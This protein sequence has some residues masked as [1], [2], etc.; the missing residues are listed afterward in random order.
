V[1]SVQIK[2]RL[3]RAKRLEGSALFGAGTPV[4]PWLGKGNGAGQGQR[5]LAGLRPKAACRGRLRLPYEVGVGIGVSVGWPWTGASRATR[6]NL[7]KAETSMSD[8]VT[9]WA[10]VSSVAGTCTQR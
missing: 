8:T 6:A 5:C 2:G 9:V 3:A 10:L 1:W 4:A 7:I